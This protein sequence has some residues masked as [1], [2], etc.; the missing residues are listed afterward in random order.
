MLLEQPQ[1]AIADVRGI[2]V[3]DDRLARA[4][5]QR[6]LAALRQR[7]RRVDEHHQLVV[8]EHHR[9]EPRFG[10][11]KRQHAEIEPALRD[12]RAELPRRDATH[13][14]VHQRMRLR[15]TGR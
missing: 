8:A 15:G 7:V 12:F 6:D 13:V 5:G 14:D 11:L 9:A 2:V 1:H 3:R 10:R 4:L